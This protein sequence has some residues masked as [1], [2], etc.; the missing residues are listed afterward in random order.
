M[1]KLVLVGLIGLALG[2]LA[3]AGIPQ[4]QSGVARGKG[5]MP[6]MQDC[7]TNI[8]GVDVAVANIDKGITVTFT[9]KSANVAELQRRV[10]RMVK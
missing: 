10:E 4:N 5:Q 9:A 3:V 8:S 6:M 2:V 7:P 1:R